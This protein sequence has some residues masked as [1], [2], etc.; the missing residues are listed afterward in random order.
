LLLVGCTPKKPEIAFDEQ[1]RPKSSLSRA[2]ALTAANMMA[3]SI[4]DSKVYAVA[5]TH[6]M[7]P[8]LWGNIYVVVE[9]VKIVNVQRGD[10]ILWRNMPESIPII[11]T[12]IHNSGTR[13]TIKGYNNFQG[14]NQENKFITESNLVGR[15][16]G[17]VVFDPNQL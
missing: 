7:E 4:P 3:F 10:I 15:Y 2:Q 9:P 1:W 8:I 5:E 13:L 16:V 6:S 12:C 17:H 11:H 14:D